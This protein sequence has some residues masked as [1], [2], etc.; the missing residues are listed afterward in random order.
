MA[1]AQFSWPLILQI[2]GLINRDFLQYLTPF[3]ESEPFQWFDTVALWPQNFPAILIYEESNVFN[4]LSEQT[5]EQ[6]LTIRC[7][8][9]L[10]AVDRNI[11]AQSCRAYLGALTQL[12]AYYDWS[13][14][15]SDFIAPVPLPETLIQ[16]GTR[17][18]NG[19]NTGLTPGVTAEVN[20][21]FVARHQFD[22]F[23]PA[24]AGYMTRVSA[25]VTVNQEESQE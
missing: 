13:R 25:F 15:A 19:V 8:I 2:A 11:L 23:G 14:H 16:L 22:E 7:R 4:P 3:G 21:I 9:Q 1:A 12:F 24:G 17:D 18:C 5:F 10:S 6:D 20:R